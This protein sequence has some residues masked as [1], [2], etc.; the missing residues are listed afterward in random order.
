MTRRSIDSE[1][2][3]EQNLL[4]IFDQFPNMAV[5]CI[6]KKIPVHSKH[7]GLCKSCNRKLMSEESINILVGYHPIFWKKINKKLISSK[8]LHPSI[9]CNLLKCMNRRNRRP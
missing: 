8:R 9:P 3:N 2:A 4:Q 5:Y 7:P 1:G 6:T